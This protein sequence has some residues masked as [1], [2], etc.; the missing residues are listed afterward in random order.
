METIDIEG[1][2]DTP[3]VILDALNNK[4]EIS[5]RSLPENPNEFYKPVLEWL[6]A[7]SK[8]PNAVTKFNFKLEYFNTASAKQIFKA[9]LIL[10]NVSK[11]NKVV[12]CWY[13]HKENEDMLASGQR[14]SKLIDADIELKEY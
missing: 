2:E 10:K 3:R 11:K 13:Y 7:Y 6:D 12:I 9:F 14:Y 1:T 4:F 5:G 8:Q